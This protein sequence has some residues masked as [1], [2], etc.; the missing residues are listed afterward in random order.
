MVFRWYTYGEIVYHLHHTSEPQFSQHGYDILAE[1]EV[2]LTLVEDEQ[3]IWHSRRTVHTVHELP[4]ALERVLPVFR[5][6]MPL[7]T[8]THRT[9]GAPQQGRRSN[10]AA[11][12]RA[13]L[14]GRGPAI[15]PTA[16]A[17]TACTM[18]PA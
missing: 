6:A 4:H 15:Q 16:A 5:C 13:A 9:G 1:N 11:P 2:Q 7:K 17:S 14:L 3:P 18:P 10:K 8:H 12:S